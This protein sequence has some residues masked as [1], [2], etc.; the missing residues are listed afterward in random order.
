VTE[1]PEGGPLFS[2]V[3]PV[4]DPPIEA[5]RSTIESVVR[6]GFTDWE[7]ILVDDCSTDARVRTLIEEFANR[8]ERVRPLFRSSN[9]HIVAASND[10]IRL[11][12][13]EFV[14]LL[15]HDDLLVQDALSTVSRTISRHED[16]DFFYSD[17]RV[18]GPGGKVLGE[19]RKPVW[20]PERLRGQMYTGHLAV[21]RRSLVNAVGGFRAGFDGSQDHDLALRVSERAR[22]VVHIPVVLYE[23]RGV[24]GSTVA[25]P[26]SKPYAFDAGLR[27]VQEHLDR[28]G[29]DAK[30]EHGPK[31]GTYVPRR[32]LDESVRVSVVIPTR[33][34]DGLVWGQRRVFVVEAV[35]SL[36]DRGGHENLQVV[37]VYDRATPSRVLRE[38]RALPCQDLRLVPY[39]REFNF[40]EKCNLGV[41]E[42]DGEVV[43]L[44]NDDVEV[45]SPNFLPELVAPL[46]E[47]GV[48]LTGARLLFSDSTLQHAGVVVFQGGPGH[49]FYKQLAT[50][51]GPFNIL[52]VN[53]ECSALTGA[54]VAIRR[55]LY[56]EVGGMCE[57][58]PLSY[59]DVDFCHKIAK[60]GL[61]RVL[62]SS[63]TAFHFESKSRDPMVKT[64]ERELLKERWYPPI[65]DAYMPMYGM[66]FDRSSFANRY[67]S[68]A[69]AATGDGRVDS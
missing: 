44:F 8:D 42:S 69:T 54:C 4:Y 45:E 27:A 2:I 23:W 10:G 25:D 11:A 62:I 53:R 28:V 39:D 38:L 50:W 31:R 20:S 21:L 40:S 6:Q 3:T 15:D 49:A 57:D 35:R 29:I 56:D 1:E 48:G 65:R 5:L 19:F 37:V 68:R 64:W 7:L 66:S 46:F 41:L 14:V 67:G 9:G 36:I 33:G 47:D 55:S 59:N 16:A 52:A 12:K 43:V 13:G 24:E 61:R 51:S 34:S 32:R 30:A 18:V 17:E 63:A 22:R 58:L 60:L 26:A